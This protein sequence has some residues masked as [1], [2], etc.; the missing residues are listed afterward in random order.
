[1]WDRRHLECCGALKEMRNLQQGTLSWQGMHASLLMIA[2]CILLS[3]QAFFLPFRSFIMASLTDLASS[4]VSGVC[5]AQRDTVA[6]NDVQKYL[7][8]ERNTNG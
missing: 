4:P 5:T 1:M 6:T 2:S 7:E 8:V 3:F